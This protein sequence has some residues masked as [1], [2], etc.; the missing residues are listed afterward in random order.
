MEL[1]LILAIGAVVISIFALVNSYVTLK[2]SE[3]AFK[4]LK[5]STKHKIRKKKTGGFLLYKDNEED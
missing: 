3:R 4:A 1:K 5:K 2:E